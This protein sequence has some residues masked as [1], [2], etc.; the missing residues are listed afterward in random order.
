MLSSL[1]IIQTPRIFD[2]ITPMQKLF[3]LISLTGRIAMELIIRQS[4]LRSKYEYK[5]YENE[6]LIY[7]GETKEIMIPQLRK[8]YL[9][10]LSDNDVCVLK[11]ES[12]FKLVLGLIPF[13]WLFKFSV[14]PFIY[15]DGSVK[16]GF[17]FPGSGLVRGEI[18][19]SLYEMRAHTGNVYSFYCCDKQIGLIEEKKSEKYNEHIYKVTFNKGVDKQLA[20]M[21]CIIA[22]VVWILSDADG[23]STI[24]QIS[25]RKLDESWRPGD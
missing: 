6:E 24:V 25:G 4:K 15:Y 8:I 1:I 17:L 2:V 23:Y 22:D 11:Q 16:K 21:L 7:I 19:G 10:D 5:V 12:W 9:R 14:P 20:V 18:D 13:I 3:Y